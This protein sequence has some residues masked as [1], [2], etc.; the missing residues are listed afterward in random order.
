MN[1]SESRY[2][3]TAER[4][5][6]AFLEIL[7]KKDF[8]YITVKEICEKAGVNRS[9]FYLHYETAAD[10]L[11]E[12]TQHIIKQFLDSMPQETVPFTEKIRDCPPEELYLITPEYLTPYL[13]Y[14]RAH[15]RVFRTTIEQAAA[16]KMD[17]AYE[18]LNRHVFFPILE[19]FRIP[20]EERE[21]IMAFYINGLI[22][23]INGWILN[24]C[25]E[26][27][28]KITAIMQRCIRCG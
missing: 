3:A 16:L 17:E 7:E 26:P 24:G 6:E 27:I 21:Y 5:D 22:A 10:L 19:R 12:S 11:A 8:A 2:F 4:M 28:E 18:A 20:P 25:D 23:V 13:R 14:I 9:T 1:R 15:R